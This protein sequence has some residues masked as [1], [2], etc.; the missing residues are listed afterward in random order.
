MSGHFS[1]LL[2]GTV[3]GFLPY[4]DVYIT[5]WLN[6][7]DIPLSAGEFNLDDYIDYTMEF[8][9]V[10]GP[11]LNVLAVC[12]PAVP[13]LCAVS[14]MSTQKDPMVPATMT[15]IGGPIDARKNPTAVNKVA[16]ERSD[17]WFEK[18]VIT[19]VPF[20]YPGFMRPVYAGFIQLG[21]FMAMNWGKHVDAHLGLFQHLVEGDGDSADAHREFYNEYLSVMDITAEFYMQTIQKV[22][23]EFDLANHR[24]VSRDRPV[25][26][27]D[28]TQT[29][30]LVIEGSRD[31]ISGIGQTKAALRL[32]AHL[33]K[34]KK[35]YHL[36]KD[37]GH[38][39]LFNG[40]RFREQIIP[41][42]REFIQS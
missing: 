25:N 7:R 14:L 29:R 19:R 11:Q 27:A 8:C 37:V 42:I 5:D 18:N 13:V 35:Q 32:C 34:D 22:F 28:I 10:L 17:I 15:L 31:D 26:P 9:R 41:V 4:Y 24:F 39:G 30:L 2:R 3:E 33:P 16:T 38:Y 1:T 12:Q 6:A 40:R 23:K 20:N 21:G 36:Q